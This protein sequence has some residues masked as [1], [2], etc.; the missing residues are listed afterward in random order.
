MPP[1]GVRSATTL[2]SEHSPA[3]DR[4]GWN[5]A[6]LCGRICEV[7]PAEAASDTTASHASAVLTAAVRLIVEAHTRGEPVAWISAGSPLFFPPDAEANGVDLDGVVVI[8]LSE[9][10]NAAVAADQLVRCGA[11][12]LVVID[13]TTVTPSI[14]DGILGRLAG[15][16]RGNSVLVLF[17]CA[18]GGD[19]S[20]LGSMVSLRASAR[21]RSG[22]EGGF[23][24]EIRAEKDKK[25][26]H[27]WD[28]TEAGHGPPGLS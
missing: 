24:L 11:F 9:G 27:S 3:A 22:V 18:S 19:H 12:G 2:T 8:R 26:G 1:R 4:P 23:L 13:F 10:R 25:R 20:A 16:A 6:E 14:P 7:H 5:F 17:L 15:L 28:W 21:S